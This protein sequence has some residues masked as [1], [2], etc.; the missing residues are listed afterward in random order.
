MFNRAQESDV[1]LGWA[2]YT[3]TL[4]SVEEQLSTTENDCWPLSHRYYI[5][6]AAHSYAVV[7]IGVCDPFVHAHC[8]AGL[9][10]GTVFLCDEPAAS[11]H[12]GAEW[13]RMDGVHLPKDSLLICELVNTRTPGGKR[14]SLRVLDAHTI[15]G[16]RVAALPIDVRTACVH[17][18]CAA[19][20]RAVPVAG[21]SPTVPILA[22]AVRR[23]GELCSD[24]QSNQL[25]AAVDGRNVVYERKNVRVPIKMS[26]TV[27][28]DTTMH[29]VGLCVLPATRA[30]WT[31]AW[32]ATTHAPYVSHA[33][34]E[35]TFFD[36]NDGAAEAYADV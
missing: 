8:M 31:A 23:L 21:A 4:H 15:A 19:L 5:A 13:H 11:K 3:R 16:H 35:R 34:N 24:V 28:G 17:R 29:A 22:A 33:A 9:Q 18:M 14:Q 36:A 7:S 26:C 2:V 27:G 32:S 10:N 12:S 30:D 6:G 25:T 1:P 20:R